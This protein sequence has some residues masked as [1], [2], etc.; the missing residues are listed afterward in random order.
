M[1][2]DANSWPDYLESLEGDCAE[3]QEVAHTTEMVVYPMKEHDY[4]LVGEVSNDEV[5]F[6][7]KNLKGGSAAG[8]DGVPITLFKNFLSIFMSIIVFLCNKVLTSGQWPNEWKRSLLM[9]LFK[10]GNPKLHINYRLIALVPALS[11]IMEK[12]LDTRLSKWLYKNNIIHEQQGGFRTGY[13]TVD[14]IFILK[15]LIDKYGKGKTCL[16]VGFLD[17]HKAFDSVDRE[18]L[19]D[20]LF[21]IG[22]PHLFVRLI[23]SMYI[24]VSGIVL[25]GNRFS[26]FF[27]IKLGVKQGSTLSPKLFNIFI[28]DVVD[29]LENRWAPN[30][31][32]G[33]HKLSLLLFADDI[34]LVASTPQD[35]QTLLSLIDDYLQMKKLRLN[36]EKSEVVIFK[37]RKTSGEDNYKFKFNN[38][39]LKVSKRIKYLG[40]VL[41]ENGSLKS[42]VD[43]LINRGK[44]A[45]SAIFRN[46]TIMGIK[47]LKMHKRIFNTKILPVIEY[48]AEIWGGEAA[49]KLES[50]QLQYYKRLFGL[51]QTTHSQILKGDMGL[52]SLKL[53]R[54]I[55][56]LRFWLKIIRCNEDRLVSA[57]YY[58]MLSYDSKRSWPSQIRSL[59]E[60]VGMA[61]LWNDGLGSPDLPTN[62]VSQVRFILEG[63]EIQYWQGLVLNSAT[64]NHYNQV[65]PSFG[66]EIYFKFNLPAMILCRWI[67][68][69]ANCLPIQSRQMVFDRGI[70]HPDGRYVCPL[71]RDE[72]EDLDHFLR[73]CPVLSDLREN[74]LHGIVLLLPKIL[75]SSNPT[76]IFRIGAYIEK[77]LERRKCFYN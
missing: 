64:L 15:A 44:V 27:N 49:Q 25:V 40:F 39:E 38:E 26:R 53:R 55:L 56:M 45:M 67:Q 37:K 75:Q 7:F 47:N 73:K 11:K 65:K 46:P 62:L 21:R 74:Y 10:R 16:Y 51:H 41:S 28:N 29:Y 13:G 66:E 36:V 76:T 23:V 48:G 54:S 42:H 1:A 77:G 52:F 8:V 57:A 24:C 5:K 43:E 31:S 33:T 60:S 50:L 20:A 9:P 4:D 2:P 32:L 34:A 30:V 68:L 69:R 70:V 63:Q 3:I 59:L 18:L 71:C 19:K 22:L 12:I 17:L 14:T 6:V 72:D 58:Q 35:L 61:Y